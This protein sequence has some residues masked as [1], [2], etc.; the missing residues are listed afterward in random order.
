MS[1]SWLAAAVQ[2][3]SGPDRRRNL[4]TALRLAGEA[5]DLGARLVALPEN[6]AFMGPEQER[7][8][9]AEPVDGP[10]VAALQELAR[11][12]RVF[13][14]AG[15]IAERVDAPGKTA[16]TS[17]LVADDG[18]VAAVYRKIHLF[19]VNIP[20]GA[21]YAES[22][23]VVPGDRPVLAETALGRIGLTVC[24]DL[25]FPELY[26]ALSAM[27]AEVLTVPAAFTL[28]TGKDHWEPL[29]RARAIENL[30]YVLA[31]AQVGRH[32]PTR[33]T[34]GNAMIVD[35]WGVVLA[36]CPDGEGVCVARVSRERLLRVR[37]EL[38]SLQHRRL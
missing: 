6:F 2:M 7:I 38:P 4:D 31:P 14:L 26:R 36:R 32:S 17:V 25:R 37:A 27:G 15:S 19:D 9:G 18:A 21:R 13:V 20:D 11:R 5:A 35:P 23:T 22:E 24:Y 33:V 10:T 16:N 12:R 28:F 1:S 8:A 34:Y 3:T 30:A 29:L